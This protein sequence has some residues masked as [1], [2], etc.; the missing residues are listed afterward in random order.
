[1]ATVEDILSRARQR[2]VELHLPY[3]GALL[4]REAYQLAQELPDARIVDVRT[5]AEWDWV[6]RIPGAVMLQ[7]STYPGGALNEKFLQQLEDLIGRPSA[8]VMF[9]CRSGNR[10]HHAAAAAAAAGFPQCFN[11]LEG[12][13][14]DKDATGHRNTKGGWRVAGLP[15]EQ[16]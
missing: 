10:S 3:A 9:V 4:P 1:M 14:G 8:P 11:V 2:A 12:F 13:E 5:S 16:S 15:W 6:G 7:W